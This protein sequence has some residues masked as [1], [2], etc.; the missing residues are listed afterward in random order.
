MIEVQKES[1]GF[2]YLVD[3]CSVVARRFRTEKR[4]IA[5]AQ[6]HYGSEIKPRHA[7]ERVNDYIAEIMEKDGGGETN[8][9]VIP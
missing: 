2:Y 8:N 6:K 7:E 4:A 5:Y 9:C 1:S 3:F